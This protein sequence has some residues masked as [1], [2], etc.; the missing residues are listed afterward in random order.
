MSSSR[1]TPASTKSSDWRP[2]LDAYEPSLQRA[3]DAVARFV[4]AVAAGAP[5]Y[6]LTL[7]GI[8]GSG[9]TMLAK[10]AFAEASQ[11]NPGNASVWIA[12]H[13]I[14]DG[15]NR[16]PRCVWYTLP[17]FK[18]QMLGG[19]YGLPEYLRQDFL[20]A[21]DDLGAARDTRDNALAEGLY[22]LAD[23]RMGRWMLWTTNLTLK[24]IADR[25]DPRLSSRLIRDEN[26]LVAISAPDYALRKR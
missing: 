21:M 6:W 3:A 2:T 18:E 12:G 5:P 10:Q 7:T 13:G 14:Y 17:D 8:Q 19:D 11:Y 20:V 26:R 23:Q 22:R 9:K 24:E 4:A 1:T 15:S 25:W 16:R